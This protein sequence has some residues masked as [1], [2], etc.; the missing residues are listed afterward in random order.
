PPVAEGAGQA[1]AADAG[2]AVGGVSS[3]AHEL[4]PDDPVL[5]L[6]HRALGSQL[7][8]LT[9]PAPERTRRPSAEGVHRLRVATRRARA[10]IRAFKGVLPAELRAD[11]ADELKWLAGILG[12]MRDLDVYRE[13]YPAYRAALPPRDAAALAP[14]ERHLQSEAQ[15]ASAALVAALDSVR[16]ERLLA[17]LAASVGADGATADASRD[18]G[19]SIRDAGVR[20]IEAAAAGV[21]KRGRRVRRASP[22]SELHEL[23][24]AGKKLRYLVE[25]LEPYFD[26]RLAAPRKALT[27]LQGVLGDYQDASAADARVRRYAEGKASAAELLALGQ[28]LGAQSR[29]ADAARRRFGKRW[30]ELDAALTSLQLGDAPR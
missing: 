9:V 5:L 3:L 16:Y 29:S 7:P 28:L 18:K 26:G 23:R 21:L 4:R 6:A 30:R 27:R 2:Q 11:V 10:A 25:F 14:F 19:E 8:A 1:V 15:Q 12:D 22:A 20:S 13:H 17:R 24:K